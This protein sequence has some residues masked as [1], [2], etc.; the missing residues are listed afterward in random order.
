MADGFI[1]DWKDNDKAGVFLYQFFERKDESMLLFVINRLDSIPAFDSNSN[2]LIIDS[3]TK[4]IISDFPVKSTNVYFWVGAKSVNYE[5]NFSI[6]AEWLEYIWGNKSVFIEFQYNESLQF[7]STFQ[8]MTKDAQYH[9]YAIQ[10]FN[11]ENISSMPKILWFEM[12]DTVKD[13]SGKD[14][15]RIYETVKYAE[16]PLNSSN[17]YLYLDGVY[18]KK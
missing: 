16:A 8:R 15:F 9:F 13:E 11:S 10:Y 14:Y 7:L 18:D 4:N 1:D 5:R 3:Q 12:L 17:W 6:V 2:Y